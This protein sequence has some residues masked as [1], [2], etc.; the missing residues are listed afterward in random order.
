MKRAAWL[1]MLAGA[2]WGCK[3]SKPEPTPEKG[4]TAVP[5]HREEGAHEDIPKLVKL[6]PE[7]IREADVRT[8][9]AR[10]RVLAAAAELSGQ[11]VANPEALAMIGAMLW[12]NGLPRL[13]HPLF[14]ARRFHLASKDRFF[15]CILGDEPGLEPH[16][17]ATFLKKAGALSVEI[18]P[19]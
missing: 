19:P 6:T 2:A 18:V 15:L 8:E 17:A 1:L 3:K 10:R 14:A 16:Q 4:A 11:I 7:V 12:Q 9:P 13:N 5:E